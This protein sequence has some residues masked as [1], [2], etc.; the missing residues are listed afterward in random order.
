MALI[1]DDDDVDDD[2]DDDGGG[3]CSATPSGATHIASIAFIASTAVISP[4]VLTQI[5]SDL[6]C[7]SCDLRMWKCQEVSKYKTRTN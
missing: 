7:R 6:I 4:A 3:T 2:D 5:S 1:D